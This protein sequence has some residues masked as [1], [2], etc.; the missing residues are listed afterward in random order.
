MDKQ[1]LKT[2]KIQTKKIIFSQII[3]DRLVE[4]RKINRKQ[5][6]EITK[7]IKLMRYT[8]HLKSP[9]FENKPNL[10]RNVFISCL[11]DYSSSMGFSIP[12]AFIRHQYSTLDFATFS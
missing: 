1:E 4:K 10:K 2:W 9:A 3:L 12:T 7:K 8:N 11:K 6:K 5:K